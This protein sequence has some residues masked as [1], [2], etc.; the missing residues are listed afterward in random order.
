MKCFIILIFITKFAFADDLKISWDE[1][2]KCEN[3]RILD[4]GDISHYNIF[5]ARSIDRRPRKLSIKME[6]QETSVIL[7]NFPRSGC[8]FITTT[9]TKGLTSKMSAP[10]CYD[11]A[12]R[13]RATY[14]KE[15]SRKN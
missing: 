2:K 7:S 4:K 8:F 14:I 1:P 3:G 12:N 15:V 11:F 13:P 5:Y 9:S 6:W 10:T